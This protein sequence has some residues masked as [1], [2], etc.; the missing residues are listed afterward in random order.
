MASNDSSLELEVLKYAN[1]PANPDYFCS[2]YKLI[3]SDKNTEVIFPSFEYETLE[4][5]FFR[6]IY[7]SRIE[8]FQPR[9]YMR[10]DYTSFDMYETPIFWYIILFVNSIPSIEE[11][12]NLNY[13]IIPYRTTI[14]DMIAEK[15]P[16]TEIYTYDV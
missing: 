2:R 16:R 13:V 6:L 3:D 4:N 9:W 15:V 8:E 10:P 1:H 11:Y 12:K 7:N 14:S 5:N